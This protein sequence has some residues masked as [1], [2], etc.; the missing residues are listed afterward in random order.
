MFLYKIHLYKMCWYYETKLRDKD[1]YNDKIILNLFAKVGG[2]FQ[3]HDPST[4]LR[5][6]QKQALN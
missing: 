3:Y 2:I 6:R 5:V 1:Y 4:P